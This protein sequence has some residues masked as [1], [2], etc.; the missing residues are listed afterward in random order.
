MREIIISQPSCGHY[1]LSN[2]MPA[3]KPNQFRLLHIFIRF[4]FFVLVFCCFTY[5][6]PKSSYLC[7]FSWPTKSI[8]QTNDI[9]SDDSMCQSAPLNYFRNN[10]LAFF[11]SFERRETKNQNQNKKKKQREYRN[12]RGRRFKF[13]HLR[14]NR[15][16]NSTIQKDK[17]SKKKK[18]APHT[19]QRQLRATKCRSLWPLSQRRKWVECPSSYLSLPAHLLHFF[20]LFSWPKKKTNKKQKLRNWLTGCGQSWSKSKKKEMR[21]AFKL[22]EPRKKKRKK[23]K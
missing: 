6:W 17:N 1:L 7:L 10:Q 8:N 15:L 4:L 14:S 20:F 18:R 11:F 2:G 22:K 9:D 3:S 21:N 12:H 19:H 5:V 13:V 16:G 23:L